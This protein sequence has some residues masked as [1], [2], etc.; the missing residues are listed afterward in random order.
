MGACH[1][2]KIVVIDDVLAF[3]GGIDMTSGRWDTHEHRS[4]GRGDLQP[5]HDM[6]VA[7]D[8]EAARRLA[9]LARRR[10]K[11]AT[12]EDLPV[13]VECT[14]I[15]PEGLEVDIA[16]TSVGIA[17]TDPG[18]GGK[19]QVDEVAKLWCAAIRSAEHTI[20]IENQYLSSGSIAKALRSRL[21][22]D[23]GP[24]I[25]IILPRSSESWLE[26]EVMDTQRSKIVADL[27]AADKGGRLGVYHPVNALEDNIYVH[28]KLLIVDDNFVR[29]GSS[30]M[31]SRSLAIDTEC[32]LAME[33]F[34]QPGSCGFLTR[35]RT[36]LMAEHLGTSVETVE[37]KLHETG[38][39][40]HAA[41]ESLRKKTGRTLQVLEVQEL[42]DSEQALA[43][44][45]MM[46]P[47]EPIN[48]RRRLADFA[49]KE[50]RREAG[51]TVVCGLLIAAWAAHRFLRR[52]S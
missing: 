1:H 46:D 15:W 43:D 18:Y 51:R 9:E 47:E 30:N 40:I 28:A 42:T 6:T 39:S 26:S 22:E 35:L 45:R 52:R 11:N 8:G 5:W 10:W 33:F 7:L 31:S 36:R 13:P 4:S 14:A 3:C 25:V 32:D 37:A 20:Y 16:Q 49:K 38:G 29:V 50:L 12:D 17:R 41:I 44:S 48:A 19:P 23:A 27:R 24:E 2:Q 34:D 21:A